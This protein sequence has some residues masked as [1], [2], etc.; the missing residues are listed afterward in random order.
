MSIENIILNNIK[1]GRE[2]SISRDKLVSITGINDRTIRD[3]IA[4]LRAEGVPIISNTNK[5]GYYLPATQEEAQEYI[6]SMENR[7]KNTFVSIKATKEWLKN[8][9]MFMQEKL[10]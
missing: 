4:D 3:T 5:G 2:N 10:F 8:N 9:R 6:S 1:P 7:A